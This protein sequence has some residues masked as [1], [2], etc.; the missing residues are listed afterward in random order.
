[1]LAVPWSRPSLS[2]SARMLICRPANWRR[3]GRRLAVR[4]PTERMT[5]QVWTGSAEE[6]VYRLRPNLP[7]ANPL[8]RDL[9][10]TEARPESGLL[11]QPLA[12]WIE[13]TAASVQPSELPQTNPAPNRVSKMPSAARIGN[14][15]VRQLSRS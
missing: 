1:M 8:Q 9:L 12:E 6:L 15:R 10:T 7:L 13:P 4:W 11:P 3:L 2:R 14:R 5:S